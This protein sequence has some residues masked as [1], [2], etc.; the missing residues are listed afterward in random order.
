M[1]KLSQILLL[2]I[3]FLSCESFANQADALQAALKSAAVTS[4]VPTVLKMEI[5]NSYHCPDCYD[6]EIS[7]MKG[8]EP[9]TIEVRTQSDGYHNVSVTL[10]TA[11]NAG[12]Q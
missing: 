5:L 9:A 6:I 10:M 1:G 7:G 12:E 11:P 8:Q 3:S 2:V 4:T